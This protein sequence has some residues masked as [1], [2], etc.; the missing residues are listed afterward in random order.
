MQSQ[1]SQE[2]KTTSKKK[3][4]RNRKVQ[5]YPYKV[6]E[7][8]EE[9]NTPTKRRNFKERSGK[10]KNSNKIGLKRSRNKERG[11]KKKNSV[12]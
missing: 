11:E 2:S 7:R 9:K 6:N 4:E 5:K 8:Q 10:G 3:C 12:K 1:E